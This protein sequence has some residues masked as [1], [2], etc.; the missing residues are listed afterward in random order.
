MQHSKM[1]KYDIVRLLSKV[2]GGGSASPLTHKGFENLALLE[3]AH[4]GGEHYQ[5]SLATTLAS[6]LASDFGTVG[7][8]TQSTLGPERHGGM[9]RRDNSLPSI[10]NKPRSFSIC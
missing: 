7:R 9:M 3:A 5:A 4:K 6:T 1:Q 8:S 10:L 2:N